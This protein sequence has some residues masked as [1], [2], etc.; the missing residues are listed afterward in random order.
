M[1][2]GSETVISFEDAN[3]CFVSIFPSRKKDLETKSFIGNFIPGKIY[4][5]FKI[6]YFS[7]EGAGCNIHLLYMGIEKSKCTTDYAAKFLILTGEDKGNFVYRTLCRNLDGPVA[8][9]IFAF[10]LN[11]KEAEL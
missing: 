9:D 11:L 4:K 8:S 10:Y 3:E 7:G 1:L 5:T 6:E 2:G